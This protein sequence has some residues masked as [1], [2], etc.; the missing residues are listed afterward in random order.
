VISLSEI[1]P[2]LINR[3]R[4]IFW[5]LTSFLLGLATALMITLL[6]QRGW[7]ALQTILLILFVLLMMQVVFGFTLAATGF[8]LLLRGGDP[9]RIN[10]TVP[11]DAQPKACRRPPS[12]CR[13]TTR[14]WAG[15]FKD[16]A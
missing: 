8:W 3:R 9:V 4:L 7:T 10:N 11:P 1:N 2:S 12:L 13:F 5:C 14:R 15:S 16:C 6:S